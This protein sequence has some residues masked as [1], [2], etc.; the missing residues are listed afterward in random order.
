MDGMTYRTAPP[1]P[2]KKGLGESCVRSCRPKDGLN[3]GGTNISSGGFP[4]AANR[5]SIFLN[6][7]KQVALNHPHWNPAYPHESQFG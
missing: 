4:M 1:A 6:E 2:S 7:E 3:H 5:E